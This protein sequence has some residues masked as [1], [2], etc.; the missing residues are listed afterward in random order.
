MLAKTSPDKT[1]LMILGPVLDPRTSQPY[2][3]Q[4]R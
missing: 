1:E 3:D 4:A 2:E